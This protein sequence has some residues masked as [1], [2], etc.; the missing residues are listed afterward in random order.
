MKRIL[1]LLVLVGL[2]GA[3][4]ESMAAPQSYPLICRGG[5]RMTLGFDSASSASLMYFTKA[6]GPAGQGLQAGQCSWAD[7]AI[8]QNE[9]PCIRQTGVAAQVWWFVSNTGQQSYA[10]S[11]QAPWM[12]QM[13]DGSKFFTFQVYNPGNGCFVVTRLGP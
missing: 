10:N 12:R 8:G 6:P 3:A 9:P 13:T 1:S 5:G 2:M 4:A 11:Q 7:R